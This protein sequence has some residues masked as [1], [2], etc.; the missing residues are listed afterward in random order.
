VSSRRA[1]IRLAGLLALLLVGGL[2]A[3]AIASYRGQ[4]ESAARLADERTARDEF[5]RRLAAT[6]VRLDA[7][8]REFAGTAAV[9]R[10]REARLEALAR[11]MRGVERQIQ[12]GERLLPAYAA[13]VALIEATV[14]YEDAAGRPLRYRGVAARRPWRGVLGPPPMDVDGEGGVVTTT[15][16]GTGFLVGRDGTVLTTGTSSGRGRARKRWTRSASWAWSPAWPR[17]APSSR[18]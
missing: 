2:V 17:S 15:F 8:R 7:L 1:L 5:G 18:G 14:H 12:A 13:G 11:R 9:L 16:L 6:D 10:E 3:S 4:Q